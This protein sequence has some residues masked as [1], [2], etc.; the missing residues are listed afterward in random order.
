MSE[1]YEAVVVGAGPAGL[2]AAAELSRNG[3]QT[4]VLERGKRAGQKSIT[5]GILYGQT[6]TPYNLD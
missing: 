1:K 6:N 3:V 5:G 4:L 2:A